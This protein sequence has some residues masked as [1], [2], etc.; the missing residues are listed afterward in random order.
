MKTWLI[1][2]RGAR[3]DGREN[4][5]ASFKATKKYPLGWVELDLHITKDNIVIC[6]HDFDINGILIAKTNYNDLLKLDSELVTFKE[7]IKV[8]DKVNLIVEIKP[9]SGVAKQIVKIAKSNLNWRF[10][11]FYESNLHELANL[12][13]DKKRMYLSQHKHPFNQL[14][15]SIDQ[16]WG[17]ITL[18]KSH[19]W[20]NIVWRAKKRNL[21]I[22][23][24]TI[25]STI[26]AGLIRFIYPYI[27][28][29]TDRPDK[30]MKLK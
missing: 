3:C 20:P 7:I 10:V 6:H 17:G 16:G 11:S 27:D 28:I 13:I 21:K 30:L 4:T 14:K 29:C 2:H 1:G 15:K 26:Y 5:L 22:Y 9:P 19:L 24:Y 25:N 8:L 12:G 23:T 18:N